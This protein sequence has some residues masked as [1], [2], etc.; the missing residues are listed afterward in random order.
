LHGFNLSKE[1]MPDLIIHFV[2]V[3]PEGLQG[4]ALRGIPISV[5]MEWL[6]ISEKI[7]PSQNP[8]PSQNSPNHS[9]P[10]EMDFKAP[11]IPSRR[12]QW[13]TGLGVLGVMVLMGTL[14]LVLALWTQS[15]RRARDLPMRFAVTDSLVE[16]VA[17][18]SDLV[19]WGKVDFPFGNPCLL[20][21]LPESL[22]SLENHGEG[23]QVQSNGSNEIAI[24][25]ESELGLSGCRFLAIPQALGISKTGQWAVSRKFGE[26]HANKGGWVRLAFQLE[27]T[28]P[29][30]NPSENKE[31]VLPGPG[32]PAIRL[33][34]KE[35]VLEWKEAG[36][37]FLAAMGVSIAPILQ[38]SQITN[39]YGGSLAPDFLELRVGRIPPDAPAW[40]AAR[41]GIAS[42]HT[43]MILLGQFP[44][45]TVKGVDFPSD[46]GVLGLWE[47][48]GNLRAEWIFAEQSAS[49]KWEKVLVNAQLGAQWKWIK[50]GQVISLQRKG[51]RLW[52]P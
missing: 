45:W 24:P 10:S 43:A 7:M 52:N 13:I 8:V 51:S 40:L 26:K 9:L 38:T 50:Q 33:N 31:I 3:R 22:D 20:N 49:D 30:I 27:S 28:K 37:K 16:N 25:K 19:V 32:I 44:D 23:R 1:K 41:G 29:G 36:G 4:K 47:E 12:A 17:R 35:G 14:G 18:G 46:A 42:R 21:L 11:H 15:Q 6:P 5:M 34:Q 39:D 2:I 48:A